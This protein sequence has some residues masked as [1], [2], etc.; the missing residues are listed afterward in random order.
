MDHKER[1]LH[2]LCYRI[3]NDDE[4]NNTIQKIFDEPSKQGVSD[5]DLDAYLCQHIPE[6]SNNQNSAQP[7][8]ISQFL[9]KMSET[10]QRIVQLMDYYE[11]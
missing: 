2:R 5:F 4:Q 11:K 8:R 10:D 9:E 7:D 6:P 1:E 3:I